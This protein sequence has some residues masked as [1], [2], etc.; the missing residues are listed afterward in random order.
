MFQQEGGPPWVRIVEKVHEKLDTVATLS[1]YLHFRIF[2]P[3]F[4]IFLIFLRYLFCAL[5]VVP[6]LGKAQ[7]KI[8]RVDFGTAQK[9]AV[10]AYIYYILCVLAYILIIKFIAELYV[11]FSHVFKCSS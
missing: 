4:F 1:T 9:A 7:N 10:M 6:E 8:L 5:F 3:Q 2:S 11:T